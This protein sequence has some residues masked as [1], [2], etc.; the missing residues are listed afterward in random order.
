M[1][2]KNIAFN[3]LTTDQLY[4]LLKVRCDIFIVEQTCPYPD[5]DNL[6]PKCRHLFLE[7]QGQVLAYCRLIPAG[8]SYPAVSIGRV[9]CRE[10]QRGKG[11]SRTMMEAAIAYAK[12]QWQANTIEISA[13][14]Y[15]KA[16]YE[17]LDFQAISDVY[18][19]DDIPHIDMRWQA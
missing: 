8:L 19:E 12:D 15:L 4:Q 18:L 5:I 7:D 2:W 11:Y 13:Q 17:S 9:L 3:E 14:N 16:F 10:D 6:D 1:E